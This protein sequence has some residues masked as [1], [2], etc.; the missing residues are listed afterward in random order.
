MKGRWGTP[1]LLLGAAGF[2]VMGLVA[3]AILGAGI[4]LAPAAL[5]RWTG[6]NVA[7]PSALA[8]LM[9]VAYGFQGT[10]LAAAVWRGRRLGAGGLGLRPI[11]DWPLVLR[12]CFAMLIWLVILVALT[13]W[14]PALRD[15][16]RSK[17]M[18]VL[19]DFLDAGP[20]VLTAAAVLITAL[21][22][23]SEELFFR[24][25]LWEALARR[26]HGMISIGLWTTLPWLLLHGLDSPGR[27][28]F[29]VPAAVALFTA[30]RLDGGVR[31]SLAVHVVNNSAAV[32]LE[33]VAWLTH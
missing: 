33:A 30:R 7:S 20:I 12:L 15:L 19:T 16:A 9:A 26:G 27:V 4:T 14:F 6:V 32:I 29:L 10:L 17:T 2:V 5:R 18:D 21:A 8:S 28:V 31:A 22:P 23:V 25:W 1:L 13:T 24:G 11:R 3:A